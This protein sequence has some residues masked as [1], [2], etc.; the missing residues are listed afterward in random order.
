[1]YTNSFGLDRRVVGKTLE[2]ATACR[3]YG[4]PVTT[5]ML[6]EDPVLVDF[7]EEFTEAN[8]GRA[9]YTAPDKLGSFLLVDFLKN[10]RRRVN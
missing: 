8:R 2:E 10:R 3:R 4:I 5:F 6:T 7:V 1:M 9:Y